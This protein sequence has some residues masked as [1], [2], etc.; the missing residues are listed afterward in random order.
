MLRGVGDSVVILFFIISSSP[1]FHSGWPLMVYRSARKK[2][3][4]Q[5]SETHSRCATIVA[6]SFR[7]GSVPQ[8]GNGFPP[9]SVRMGHPKRPRFPMSFLK[10]KGNSSSS[11]GFQEILA[12]EYQRR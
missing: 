1:C 12:D 5:R 11:Y 7:S 3:S 9:A 10:K 4:E 2:D 8:T 6:S